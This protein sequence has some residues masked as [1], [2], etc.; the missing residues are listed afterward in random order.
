M[1]TWTVRARRP[2]LGDE[3][4]LGID[5]RGHGVGRTGER[6]HHAVAL[7]LLD[8]PHAAVA[9]DDLVQDLVVP[10][11]RHG[12]R[13]GRPFPPPRR[14]LDVGQQEADR[15]GRKREARRVGAAHVV[16]QETSD[17]RVDV[18]NDHGVSIRDPDDRDIPHLGD[19]LPT[20]G[21]RQTLQ[22]SLTPQPDVLVP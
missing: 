14:P 8:R 11:N 21:D 12:H 4:S 9:G 5:R 1:R 20:A 7:A 2:G 22:P 17:R 15:S 3:R 10:G 6:A 13:F 19:P 16:H 18:M